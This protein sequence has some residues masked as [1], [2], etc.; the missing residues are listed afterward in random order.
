MKKRL[1]SIVALSLLIVSC[2][3]DNDI[4]LNP[5]PTPV[6]EYENGILVVGEGGFDTSGTVSFV[7]EANNSSETDIYFDVNEEEVGSFFQS[8]G[9][10]DGLAYLVVDNG[11]IS[12]VNRDSFE[13][14]GSITTGLSTPRYIAFANGKGYVSNWGDP[15][16]ESDDF[17]AVLDLA[18]NTVESTIPV[19]LGPEQLVA[20]E[21][22]LFVSHKGAY[23]TNNVVSVINVVTNA[24]ETITVND[25]P[26]EMVINTAGDLVVLSGGRTLYDANYNVIGHTDGAL[27]KINSSDN[28]I[29]STLTFENGSHPSLMSYS[30]GNLYY[31]LNNELY[32]MED[33]DTVLPDSS[34]LSLSVGYA[35]GMAVDNNKLY[36]CDASFTGQSELFVYDL[37]TSEEVNSFAVGL[38]ASKVYFN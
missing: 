8:I 22:K 14:T 35:Y 27:T 20:T 15:S 23:S 3:K 16:D 11:T 38:A 33:S 36:V 7:S 37:S 25:N 19:E 13:K 10:N 5:T 34:V 9:F 26:D 12:V 4:A 21:N 29:T 6:G 17:I 2:S 32:K 31:L 24:V 30:D 28:S 1:L 18:T